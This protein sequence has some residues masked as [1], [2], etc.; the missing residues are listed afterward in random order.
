MCTDFNSVTESREE[1]VI[2]TEQ[3]AERRREVFSH[4]TRSRERRSAAAELYSD[5][6]SQN[7]EP[8]ARRNMR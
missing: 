1:G 6:E 3:L 5:D 8:I 4:G 7:P 2:T